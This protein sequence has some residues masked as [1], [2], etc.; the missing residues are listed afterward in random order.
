M[1]LKK[2]STGSDVKLLQEKLGLVADG[3]F[4][5]TTEL[6]VIDWQKKN[7]LVA[8]GVIGDVSWDKLFSGEKLKLDLLKGYIPSQV[9]EELRLN[10]DKF[11]INTNLRLC[12]FLSQCS[13]ES[14]NFTIV[15][16]NLNYSADGLLK[17]FGKYFDKLTALSYA[18]KPIAIGS[19]VYANRMGNGNEFSKDGY[20]FRGRGYIQCTGKSN[21]AEFSD[22]IGENCVLNPDLIATKYPLSSAAFFF[23]KNNLWSICDMGSSLDVIKKLTKRINGGDIGLD[24]RVLKFNKIKTLLKI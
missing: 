20:L 13:H 6:K 24:D 9:L 2:G 1:L 4:G 22:Y 19:R 10:A 14:N 7:G 12:H 15:Y 11:G 17:V 3:D 23:K 16:E 18:K 5:S 21:Y 8:D